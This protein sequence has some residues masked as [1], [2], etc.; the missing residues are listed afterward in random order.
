[1]PDEP[2]RFLRQYSI[3]SLL[4]LMLVAAVVLGLAKAIDWYMARILIGLFLLIPV[5]CGMIALAH[6]VMTIS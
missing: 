3:R 2:Q 5:W 4:L 6:I 1:M